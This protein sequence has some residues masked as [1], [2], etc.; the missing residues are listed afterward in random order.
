MYVKVLL[1]TIV[2]IISNRQIHIMFICAELFVKYY[3]SFLIITL[4]YYTNRFGHPFELP[5]LF[6]SIFMN[7]AMLAM[8]QLCVHIRNKTVIVPT[9]S[10]LFSG[11]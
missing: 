4:L 1:D 8:V 10:R 9:K 7:L 11:K 3:F 5:L 2:F 6:Q